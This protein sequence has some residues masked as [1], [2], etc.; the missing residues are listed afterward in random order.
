MVQAHRHMAAVEHR[1]AAGRRVVAG[2]VRRGRR[3]MVVALDS[4]V[5]KHSGD[6]LGRC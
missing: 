2:P 5:D 6:M 4:V 1:R 3:R